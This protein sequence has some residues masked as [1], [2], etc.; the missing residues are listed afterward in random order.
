MPGLEAEKRLESCAIWHMNCSI[1][2]QDIYALALNKLPA[3]Y[4]QKGTIILIEL[5]TNTEVE[6]SGKRAIQTVRENTNH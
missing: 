6:L 5:V 4:I 2:I 1:D 3:R